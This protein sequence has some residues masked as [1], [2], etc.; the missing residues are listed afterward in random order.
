ME[1]RKV[2]AK[3]GNPDCLVISMNEGGG[4]G[5]NKCGE[6]VIAL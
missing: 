3:V 5:G 2:G 4:G 1:M 6:C